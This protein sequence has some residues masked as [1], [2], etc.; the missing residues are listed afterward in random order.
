V[1]T[2]WGLEYQPIAHGDI[3]HIGH[4]FVDAGADV[5]IGS[6]PHVVQQKAR[7]N[8]NYLLN[9]KRHIEIHLNKILKQ[10]DRAIL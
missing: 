3:Q 1:Y 7:Y 9:K 6:H 2:H 4:T 10:M 5:V 8:R